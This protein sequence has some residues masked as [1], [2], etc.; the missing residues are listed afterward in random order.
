[1]KIFTREEYEKYDLKHVRDKLEGT[2]SDKFQIWDPPL[3]YRKTYGEYPV[4]RWD[5]KKN[6]YEKVRNYI[7]A[8]TYR[9]KR[10]KR[11]LKKVMQGRRE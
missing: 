1:M 4:I 6:L 10:L 3:G 9:F 5:E 2:W 7:R 11:Y 8:R